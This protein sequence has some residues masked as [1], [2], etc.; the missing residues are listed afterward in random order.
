[1]GSSHFVLPAPFKVVKMVVAQ[2]MPSCKLMIFGHNKYGRGYGI[3]DLGIRK[4]GISQ[5]PLPEKSTFLHIIRV[6]VILTGH[7]VFFG[8][9]SSLMILN[10]V[11]MVI[12][13]CCLLSKPTRIPIYRYTV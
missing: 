4:Y 8:K 6:L 11:S 9:I 10:W 3:R 12:C 1:V 5:N 13:A 7:V 2:N